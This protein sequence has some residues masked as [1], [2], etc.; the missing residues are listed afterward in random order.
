MNTGGEDGVVH[1]LGLDPAGDGEGGEGGG[2][3]RPGD[4][5]PGHQVEVSLQA[6][7]GGQGHTL[8]R[9]VSEVTLTRFENL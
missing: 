2:E 7:D 1:G 5:G 6:G 8:Y 3:V 4:G 9:T